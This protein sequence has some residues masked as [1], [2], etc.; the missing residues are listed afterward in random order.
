V[1]RVAMMA[2]RLAVAARENLTVAL[3]ESPHDDPDFPALLR[4]VKDS[5]LF[6]VAEL[7]EIVGLGRSRLYEILGER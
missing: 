2:L 6:T 5:G 7:A 4:Q 3:Q 1:D